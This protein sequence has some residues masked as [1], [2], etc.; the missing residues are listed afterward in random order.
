MEIKLIKSLELDDEVFSKDN[1]TLIS[2]FKNILKGNDLYLIENLLCFLSYNPK[3]QRSFL[4][5]L[6]DDLEYLLKYNEKKFSGKYYSPENFLNILDNDLP[7]DKYDFESIKLLNKKSKDEL[8]K[9]VPYLA[10]WLYDS[11]SPI[12]SDIAKILSNFQNELL[13]IFKDV[14]NSSDNTS[15]YNCLL[16]MNNYFD[17]TAISKLIDKLQRMAYNP[18]TEEIEEDLNILSSDLLKKYNS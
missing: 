2:H 1:L 7:K 3:I 5:L 12:Y 10:Y 15:K 17:K 11:N 6:R 4:N 13:D 8:I 18:T 9:I 16:F 14:F